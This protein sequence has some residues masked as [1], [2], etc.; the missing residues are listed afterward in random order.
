MAVVCKRNARNNISQSV[1]KRFFEHAVAALLAN[2]CV[3]RVVIAV[4]PGDV[5]FSQ[6]PLASHPQITVVDGGSERADSVLAGLQALP[7]AQWVLVHDAARPCLHQDDLTRLL[8]LRETSRV[9]G[10]LGGTGSR[11]HEAR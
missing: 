2:A 5:R 8:A 4:S 10:I 1:T 6:L 9:G 3:Q 11:Y 7:D